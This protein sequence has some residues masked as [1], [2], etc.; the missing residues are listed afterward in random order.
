MQQTT[1]YG[2]NKPEYSDALDIGVINGVMD[3]IDEELF[4]LEESLAL[5]QETNTATRAIPKGTYVFWN[6]G[7]YVASEDIEEGD[8][9]GVLN[10]TAVTGGGLNA[11][12]SKAKW[13][14]GSISIGVDLNAGSTCSINLYTWINSLFL[15]LHN[16]EFGFLVYCYP[17]ESSN[18]VVQNF[19]YVDSASSFRVRNIGSSRAEDSIVVVFTYAQKE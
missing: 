19:E 6:E 7:L 15:N 5:A 12:L 13:K 2:F 8:T 4:K 18:F 3:K 10:L 14:I 1:N 16:A 11:G 9:L 17:L